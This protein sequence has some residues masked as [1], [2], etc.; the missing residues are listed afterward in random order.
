M[1]IFSFLSVSCAAFLCASATFAQEPTAT[2]EAALAA[3]ER[4]LLPGESISA[5]VNDKVITT[6]DVRQRMKLMLISAGG[7]IPPEALPQLQQQA[8]RDLVEEKLKL[9]EAEKFELEIPSD[10]IRKEIETIGAQSNLSYA[11]L[12]E[13]LTAE[14]ISLSSLEEQIRSS[15]AW[16]SLVQGRFSN[17]IRVS[18]DEVE[19]T[20]ARMKGRCE[21]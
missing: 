3:Q 19:D 7:R 1:K 20:L 8:L 12:V 10:D 4:V 16:P 5:I 6:F 21:Q 9:A 17:R 11:Q 13:L 2:D 14:G 18:D 15:L